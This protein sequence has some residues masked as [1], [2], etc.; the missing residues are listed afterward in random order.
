V[1]ARHCS[2]KMVCNAI[3][4]AGVSASSRCL[5][6]DRGAPE[7]LQVVGELLRRRKCPRTRQ[8]EHLLVKVSLSGHIRLRP[9]LRDVIIPCSAYAVCEVVEMH[10]TAEK[11]RPE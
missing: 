5:S 3:R 9:R 11:I 6:H 1:A 8:D 2:V 10:R 4:T 7:R